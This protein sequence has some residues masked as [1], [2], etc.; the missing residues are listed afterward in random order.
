MSYNISM[1]DMMYDRGYQ[2][3]ST[4]I[5]ANDYE[6][7][8][9]HRRYKSVGDFSSGFS[10]SSRQ[11]DFSNGFSSSQRRTFADASPASKQLVRVRSHSIFSCITGV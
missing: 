5:V 9:G 2:N 10:S 3:P 11:I 4:H 7:K 8:I 1:A 6:E